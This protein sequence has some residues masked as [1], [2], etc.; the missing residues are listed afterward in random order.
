V[1]GRTRSFRANELRSLLAGALT[2]WAAL[3]VRLAPRAP[4]EA[5]GFNVVLGS[6]V[7]GRTV[8][9]DAINDDQGQG[10]PTTEIFLALSSKHGFIQM[11]YIKPK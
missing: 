3:V 5:G 1:S 2:F 10:L 6:L 4:F 8:W 9:L 7:I 11:Y